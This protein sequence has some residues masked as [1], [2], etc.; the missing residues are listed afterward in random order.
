YVCIHGHFYQPPRENPWLGSVEVQDSAYPYH[1][2]NERITAECYPTNAASRVLDDSG[3]IAH[4][5][6]NYGRISFNVGPTLLA[7]MARA[8]PD[9][10]QAIV[11]ADQ[12]SQKRFSGHGSALAQAY[13]H[14]IMPLA[15]PRDRRTQVAWGVADFRHRFGRDP[16]GM[17]LPET[18]VDVDTL[19]SLAEHGIRFTILAPHQVRRVRRNGQRSFAEVTA[20]DVDTSVAYRV[21]LPSGAQLAAFVYDGPISRAVAFEGLLSDGRR[22]AE[23]LVG[24]FRDHGGPQLVHI[25]TDGE[26][27][28]HHH[29]HGDMALAFALH[30][31]QSAP[32][33]ELTNYGEFLERHPP[34]HE[35]QIAEDTSWSCAH[36]VERWRSDCGCAGGGHAAWDQGWRAPLRDA[37]DWL[38]DEMND[39]FERRA[40]ITLADPWAAR[41][42]Y[43]HVLLDRSATGVFLD[44]HAHRPLDDRGRTEVWKLLQLQRHAMLMYTSCGWFFDDLA[45]IETIQ[46]LQYAG[47][48]IELAGEVLGVDLE[49]GFLDRLARARS[50]DPAEGVGRDVYDRHV[51]PA[52]VDPAKVAV[53]Q[54]V[55]SLFDGQPQIPNYTVRRERGRTLT[56][57]AARLAVGRVTVRSVITAEAARLEYAVLHLGDHNID[58][59]VRDV[60]QDADY[61]AM[62]AELGEVF[63]VAD[64]PAVIRRLGRHFG[65]QRHSLPSLFRDEQR[66]I[67]GTILDSSVEDARAAYRA[68]F[69]PRAPLMRY[70]TDL[71]APLPRTFQRAADV[72]VNDDLQR[73]L[74]A[75]DVD[76][77]QVQAL[78]DDARAWGIDLDTVRLTRTVSATLESLVEQLARRLTEP[79][80][81]RQFGEAERAALR[82]TT[83]LAEMTRSLPFDVDLWRAQ[84]LFYDMLQLIYPDLVGRAHAGDAAA[85][86]WRAQI[87]VLGDA[88]G[89]AVA[90]GPV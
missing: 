8:A 40:G 68:I 75:D 48:A 80:L 30:Q 89:V 77:Q 74:T 78:L 44:D 86:A 83:T 39:H 51:R 38:R 27:Y 22:L 18:A 36:G 69:R 20:G 16:E 57:G 84:K 3:R 11:D 43:I 25:A 87:E 50:N 46:V 37:L 47:R 81:F 58:A 41:D 52:I 13:N 34:R 15:N 63:A 7:W 66:R 61:D 10:Y 14:V 64:F 72:V 1:D 49:G 12:E 2:W 17:W 88:L 82:H 42:D 23:R 31:L 90:A 26:S 65:D 45:R 79:S 28:G 21:A 67:L 73:A 4:V 70:L 59:G 53:N 71:G 5:I 35:L 56:A 33:V 60:G 24:A 55:S 85:A 29:R 19:E 32:D 6:N 76:P 9:V 54:V 62:A